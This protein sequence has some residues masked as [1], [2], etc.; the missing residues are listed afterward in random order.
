M[1]AL[2]QALSL[3]SMKETSGFMPSDI[4]NL[5]MWL[6][7]NMNITAD[8]D[9]A[10][11]PLDPVHTTVANTMA[12]GDKISIWNDFTSNS[13]DAIMETEEDKPEWNRLSASYPY[14][15]YF[16]GTKYMDLDKTMSITA[17]Q[18]F[19]IV[20]EVMFTNLIT[21]SIY[22]SDSS[23]FFRINAVDGS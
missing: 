17:N 16:T 18:D 23:N 21:K 14:M 7:F 5:E 11:N 2:K 9:S 15:P 22:G 8:Q 1:L 12:E 4:P 13:Y 20:T 3:V 19:S 6:K 10:G